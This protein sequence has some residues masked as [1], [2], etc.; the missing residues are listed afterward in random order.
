LETIR[1]P[2]MRFALVI[3]SLVIIRAN[4][5]RRMCGAVR[6]NAGGHGECLFA[7]IAKNYTEGL[8]D[9]KR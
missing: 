4:R 6:S 8:S 1:A 2:I 9:L 3:A 5:N 7:F